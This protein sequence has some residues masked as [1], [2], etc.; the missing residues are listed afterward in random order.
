VLGQPLSLADPIA[1][2]GAFELAAIIASRTWRQMPLGSVLVVINT[3]VIG[4]ALLLLARAVYSATSKVFVAIAITLVAAASAYFAPALAPTSAAVVLLT[5]A[6]WMNAARPRAVLALLALL[7]ATTMP[8]AVPATIVA[9]L[10]ER[11]RGPITSAVSAIVIL[12]S[13]AIVQFAMPQG[14]SSPGPAQL[15]RCAVPL[16]VVTATSDLFRTLLSITAGNVLISALAALG[17]MSL[18][19]LP[20]N[21]HRALLIL[22]LAGLWGIG[23]AP[24][25]S[26]PAIGPLLIAFWLLA[27]AGLSQIWEALGATA[28]RK[29]GAVALTLA[30]VALQGL[31]AIGRQS[32]S[33]VTD[34]H[35]KV[36]L[37]MMTAF[38]G[39]LPRG[40]ALVEEDAVTD[41]LTR[42]L[43][44][45][46]RAS[47]R[48]RTVRRDRESI[49]E[50]LARGPVVA[51]PRAQRVLQ[52]LG[53][54]L[55]DGALAG[56]AQVRQAHA[57][58]PQLG[59]SAS[60][61]PFTTERQALTLVAD[62]E[63]SYDQIVIVLTGDL[64]IPVSA[65]NWSAEAMRG[66]HGRM[67]DRTVPV[68][69]TDFDTELHSYGLSSSVPTS[70][71]ATRIEAWRVPGAPL[72]L[73][74]AI[75][76]NA[77][78][79]VAKRLGTTPEQRLRLCPSI[80]YDVRPM[81]R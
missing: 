47:D 28:G 6:A 53:F 66:I 76:T 32:T 65:I 43:P 3:I 29:T 2:P 56:L 19:R 12:A 58:T 63:N 79:G 22:I 25:V 31:S 18:E 26:A 49:T 78:F 41:L 54:E 72:A 27:A 64:P 48:F 33:A 46:M 24:S 37:T 73:P 60:P 36:S 74:I 15:L 13:V 45:R 40:A 75:G 17:L 16:S 71:Y 81:A 1:C 80:P 61:I 34:G 52:L 68:D 23:V 59:P 30:I 21:T 35:D 14:P 10:L 57:C 70:R 20:H 38:I 4:F 5:L 67:F 62:D 9:V 50:A 77:E 7:A 51:L 11:K 8:L 55:S 44:S 42:S 69:R 39:A